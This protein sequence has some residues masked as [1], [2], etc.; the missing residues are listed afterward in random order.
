MELSC[1][2]WQE[3]EGAF[4]MSMVSIFLSNLDFDTI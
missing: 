2:P 1:V 3:C 4:E